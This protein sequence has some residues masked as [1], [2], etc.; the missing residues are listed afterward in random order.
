[1]GYWSVC[2]LVVVRGGAQHGLRRLRHEEFAA[3]ECCC[4]GSYDFFYLPIDF[5]NKC[6]LG[7][8][9]I[10]FKV[11]CNLVA[12]PLLPVWL[13]SQHHSWPLTTL[14]PIV[15][16][17]FQCWQSG[18]G[19]ATFYEEYHCKRWQEFNSKKVLLSPA[20]RTLIDAKSAGSSGVANPSCA[21]HNYRCARSHTQEFRGVM[22]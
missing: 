18:A 7:Y 13:C 22:R 20:C 15:F 9:F 8:A 3:T 2:A 17:P 16:P 14:L 21:R 19:A 4:S 5:K 1:M 12:L 6:N 11:L 10:N